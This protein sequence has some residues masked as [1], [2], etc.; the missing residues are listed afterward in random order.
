MDL[1]KYYASYSNNFANVA[2][3]EEELFGRRESIL[4]R[5]VIE[6]SKNG[7]RGFF[8]FVATNFYNNSRFFFSHDGELYELRNLMAYNPMDMEV[9]SIDEDRV[10]YGTMS[11]TAKVFIS[12]AI[13]ARDVFGI[14]RHIKSGKHVAV[15][16][17]DF[18]QNVISNQKV[19]NILRS[20]FKD[21]FID[22]FGEM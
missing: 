21:Y 15:L 3:G 11:D 9:Y 16:Q 17:F 7:I 20:I 22:E 6:S 12:N 8:Y 10:V 1:Y 14:V 18:D 5:I 4:D 2:L 13:F 19:L